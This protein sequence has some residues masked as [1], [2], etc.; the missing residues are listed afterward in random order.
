MHPIAEE[1][2]KEQGYA[3]EKIDAETEQAE[4]YD[5]TEVPTF[6]VLD[7]KGAEL[8]RK[9]GAMSKKVFKKWLK[10]ILPW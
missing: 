10:G 8:S 5:I 3:L 7:D 2:A 4:K 9:T 1:L 6:V